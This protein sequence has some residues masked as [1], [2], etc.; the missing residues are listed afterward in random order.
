MANIKTLHIMPQLKHVPKDLDLAL[1]IFFT[2]LCIQTF[3]WK[4]KLYQRNG[5]TFSWK[6][7]VYQKKELG[8]SFSTGFLRS[9]FSVKA[10][11]KQ[12]GFL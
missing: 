10:F 5:E 1:A 11:A 6:E 4:R 9:K 7:K 12:K 8:F 3:L 2:L